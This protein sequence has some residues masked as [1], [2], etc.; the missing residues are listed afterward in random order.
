MG[1]ARV[2]GRIGVALRDPL[3][4][5][6]LVLTAE[7]A[8]RTGYEALFVPEIAGREAFATMAGFARATATL[9]LGS[10]VIPSRSR[11]PHTLAMGAMTVQELAYGRF[12]LG[13][14]AAPGPGALGKIEALVGF[15]REIFAGR[16]ANPPG[17]K[18][19]FHPT[20]ST[21]P[22]PPIWLAALG[23]KMMELAGRIADGVL[24]NWCTP[25]RVAQARTLIRAGAE[26]AG[27]D[28]DSIPIAVYIRSCV[29]QEQELAEAEL[30][31]AARE[32]LALAHYRR[33]FE[34]AGFD[35]ADAM[36]VARATCILGDAASAQSQLTAFRDAG[37]TLPVIYPVPV[38]ETASSIDGTI[39]G[40]APDPSSA[41]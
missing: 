11:Q 24:L 10:G 21:T 22:A 14:G 26:Q 38:L 31:S 20:F 23:P 16:D 29:G 2:Q 6:Q 35:P 18:S 36:G 27:R 9:M 3:P 17:A 30:A 19:Q 1:D 15:L 5:H 41:R 8:E 39:L 25:E 33:A 7:L 4:W 28:P 12:I 13:L 34:S 37:A 32:Y 40:L